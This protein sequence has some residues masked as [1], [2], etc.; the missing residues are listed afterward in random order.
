MMALTLAVTAPTGSQPALS[1]TAAT[2]SFTMVASV[3]TGTSGLQ[4]LS[5]T[6]ATPTTFTA[7]PASV[8]VGAVPVLPLS[9]SSVAP[10]TAIPSLCTEL[11]I[12]DYPR[13]ACA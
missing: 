10:S 6:T 5:P 9:D 8:V 12:L 11:W 3:A 7:D 2:A 4:N 13:V 1:T